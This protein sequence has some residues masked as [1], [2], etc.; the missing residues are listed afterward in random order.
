[1]YPTGKKLAKRCL[2]SKSDSLSHSNGPITLNRNPTGAAVV[3]LA[4][5]ASPVA[6]CFG[7]VCLKKHRQ[8][9]VLS[10]K[11]KTRLPGK[12]H[13]NLLE[14]FVEKYLAVLMQ[15]LHAC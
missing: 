15:L 4:T 11:K 14:L 6:D 10:K 5:C 2:N 12:A 3:T 9:G 1:M 13:S 8:T 7:L